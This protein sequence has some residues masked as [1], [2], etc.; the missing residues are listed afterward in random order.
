M[1]NGQL[2]QWRKP[3]HQFSIACNS[4]CRLSKETATTHAGRFYNS[5]QIWTSVWRRGLSANSV[6]RPLS[7]RLLPNHRRLGSQNCSGDHRIAVCRRYGDLW[8]RVDVLHPL[9]GECGAWGGRR[10]LRSRGLI[11]PR[12]VLKELE[13]CSFPHPWIAAQN[14]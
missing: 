8:I 5:R 14:R 2:N 12:P 10:C 4:Q 11:A 9:A 7:T 13:N 1:H 6:A 3:S